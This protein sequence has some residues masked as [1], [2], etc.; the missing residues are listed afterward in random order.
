MEFDQVRMP[1]SHTLL[2]TFCSFSHFFAPYQHLLTIFVL[3]FTINNIFQHLF[4]RTHC[5]RE[6][7]HGPFSS[8]RATLNTPQCPSRRLTRLSCPP[9]STHWR[10]N[11]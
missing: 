4:L 7:V 1:F 11:T 2:R 5:A 8:T 3:F 9:K 6:H 10:G